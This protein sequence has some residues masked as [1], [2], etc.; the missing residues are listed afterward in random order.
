MVSGVRSFV[1]VT[2][3]DPLALPATT[4]A[5][6]VT[7]T[8]SLTAVPSNVSCKSALPGAAGAAVATIAEPRSHRQTWAAAK[9]SRCMVKS[10][11]QNGFDPMQT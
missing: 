8:P 6:C 7:A 1:P 11:K 3:P 10:P 9:Q 2:N 5:G 4:V